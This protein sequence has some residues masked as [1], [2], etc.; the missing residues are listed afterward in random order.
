MQIPKQLQKLYVYIISRLIWTTEK[1]LFYPKLERFYASL[2]E[3]TSSTLNA[4]NEKVVIFDVGAN[5]GQSIRFFK[6]LFS[7]AEIHAFE[8]SPSTF[9]KLEG[10][11]A[12]RLYSSTYAYAIGVSETSSTLPFYESILDETSSFELPNPKS[13]YLK[14]KNRILLNGHGATSQPVLINV[15]SLENIVR[16]HE[17]SAISILKIDTEGHELSVFKGAMNLLR[18]KKIHV[19]QFEHHS[20]DMRPDHSREIS[21]LLKGFGYVQGASIKH[22]FGEFYEEIYLSSDSSSKLQK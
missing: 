18:D 3:K 7:S 6:K 5:K 16:D 4:K 1:Y 11:I 22:P 8:T 19:I 14:R 12:K 21:N 20:D 2:A 13:K 9:K 15:D 10:E 17:I